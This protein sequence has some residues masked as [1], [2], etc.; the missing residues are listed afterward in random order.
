MVKCSVQGCRNRCHKFCSKTFTDDGEIKC[1][2]HAPRSSTG[3]Y[4]KTSR[5]LSKHVTHLPPAWANRWAS[6]SAVQDKLVNE[7]RLTVEKIKADTKKEISYFPRDWREQ[8]KVDL[9]HERDFALVATKKLSQEDLWSNFLATTRKH[10]LARMRVAKR[11]LRNETTAPPVEQTAPS[12]VAPVAR[13]RSMLPGKYIVQDGP[14]KNDRL[15]V[16][17]NAGT[18]DGY[19]V[20]QHGSL[21]QRL[22]QFSLQV[23]IIYLFIP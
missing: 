9:M 6:Q 17:Y 20:Y 18:F 2:L 21:S 10:R 19:Y 23:H 7:A 5:E 22:D 13:L 15:I 14:D 12:F 4:R 11:R 8:H 3:M 1:P 16:R